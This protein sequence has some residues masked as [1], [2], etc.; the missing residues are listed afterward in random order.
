MFAL[1]LN[2]KFC[3]VP[4]PDYSGRKAKIPFPVQSGGMTVKEALTKHIDLYGMIS[5][6]TLG[7]MVHL[8]EAPADKDL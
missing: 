6:K 4:N 3:F 7:S 1:D 8:C 2:E 5:K